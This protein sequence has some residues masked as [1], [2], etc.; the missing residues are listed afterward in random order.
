MNKAELV[1]LSCFIALV[2][3]YVQIVADNIWRGKA[4]QPLWYYIVVP[5]VAVV[6][7]Y[8]VLYFTNK[9]RLEPKK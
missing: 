8:V 1:Y 2:G 5:I 3:S 9:K 6:I 7:I 4:F